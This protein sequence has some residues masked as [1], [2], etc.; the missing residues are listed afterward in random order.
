MCEYTFISGLI[1]MNIEEHEGKSKPNKFG[2]YLSM[3]VYRME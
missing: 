2:L 1:S 3:H